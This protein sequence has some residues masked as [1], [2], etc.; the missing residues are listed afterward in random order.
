MT[1]ASGRAAI[2]PPRPAGGRLRVGLVSMA[3][4]VG[5][6]EIAAER[7]ALGLREAGHEVVL[8][9]GRRGAVMERMERAGLRCRHTPMH[10]TDKWRWWRWAAARAR[11]RALLRRERP[12]V[13]H[14]ND[15]PTHQ[16][17]SG[18]ARGLG[19]PVVCHHRFPFGGAAID[20]LNKY[21]ADRHLFVSRA[22]MGQ[23]GA[24]SP[25]LAAAAGAVVYDGLELP[26]RPTD[27]DRQAARRRLGLPAGKVLVLFAGQVIERKGVEDLV[28]AWA[29][30]GPDVAARAE[31][32]IVGD[33]LQ[34]GGAYRAA[35][36]GLA[37]RLGCPARF[38]GFR[39]D[40][41]DWLV[42]ADVAAVPSHVEPLG[43]ATLEAMAQARPV[44]GSR[45][46]GIPE[47]VVP[48][49]TGLLVPPGS[50]GD[51]AAALRRLIEDAALRT[52]LG[53]QGRARCEQR[54]S[55]QEH[56]RAVVREY[57]QVLEQVAHRA[58]RGGQRC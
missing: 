23:M 9:L 34:G 57:G 35:M 6:A 12:D 41:A 3:P 36:Q 48:E 49:E 20:W 13:V 33:D 1:T 15:L 31:L 5:G 14:G 43:N 40:V 54:F 46:G 26:A 47:M 16:V 52:R 32:L 55:L 58:P 18:A 29:A 24:Q 56:V 8:I 44:V 39:G 21:G 51:L 53:E 22:L 45:V 42:A 2:V 38:V 37:E 10:L 4:F 50:P 27:G 19:I 17:L 28:R 30:L 25:R 11:L 7:L